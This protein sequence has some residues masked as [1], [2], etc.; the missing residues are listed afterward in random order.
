MISTLSMKLSI[1]PKPIGA[2]IEYTLKPIIEEAN[3]LLDRCKGTPN[4]ST[5]LAEAQ[6]IFFRQ[7]VVQSITSIIVTGMICLT[8][9][10]I[11]STSHRFN[12]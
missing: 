4:V 9:F 5:L 2:F 11:L 1:D 12:P 7:I 6:R 3:E 8:A 10:F